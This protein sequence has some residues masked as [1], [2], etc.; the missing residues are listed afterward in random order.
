MQPFNAH[1][2]TLENKN[3]DN[4]V[5][6]KA[7]NLRRIIFGSVKGQPGVA[8]SAIPVI[9]LLT[10]LL[11]IIITKGADAVQDYGYVVL[12]AAAALCL[13]LALAFRCIHRR[14]LFAGIA[15]SSRQILPAVPILIFIGTLSSTW[16]LS[17]V[18]P[19]LIY[20]G[21]D[22]INADAFLVIACSVCALVSLVTGTSWTTIATIGVAFMGIGTVMGF[23]PG[24]I[25]GAVISGAYFGDKISPL[26]DTTVLASS[27]VGVNLFRHIRFLMITTAPA[28]ITALIIYAIVGYMTDGIGTIQSEAM[29]QALSERFNISTWTL[30]IPAL[31][32]LM[33]ALRFRTDVTLALSSVAGLAGIFIFQPQIVAEL[34]GADGL[35]NAVKMSATVLFTSTS[36]TTGNELLDSLVATSGVE[37][38]L[39]TVWLVLSAMVFGGAM[40]GTGMLRS[41]THWFTSRL[42]SPMRLVGTTV[43][44][45]LFLNSCT[46]D[47]YLSLIIGS[48]MYKTVYRQ[49]G[50]KPQVLSRALEDS[51][52]VTSVLIPWNSCGLTQSTVLG[53]ATIAYLPYCI[54]N[55]LS[56]LMSLAVA[57]AGWGI[58]RRVSAY[59]YARG[60]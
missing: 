21:L 23:Q 42:R 36:V 12:S 4:K 20:Y 15:K 51:V 39:T 50:L 58:R 34:G 56:P 33:I 8:I 25:A 37:G 32:A 47:Q 18:V 48:N 11:V 6:N 22:I 26:S 40:M 30:I 7:A 16:M 13:A 28:M 45:G 2:T 24:W 49:A 54:F 3:F 59:G 27:T 53:V 57:W 1:L 10:E 35:A 17:G 52:S 38:M 9:G 41:L 29:T 44:S 60:V 46:G 55:I 14:Q 43:G 19:T 5:E 31:T